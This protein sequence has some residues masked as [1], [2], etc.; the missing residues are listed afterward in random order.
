MM[1]GRQNFSSE[2]NADDLWDLGI[3]NQEASDLLKQVY[4]ESLLRRL[5]AQ[6]V[7]SIDNSEYEHASIIHDLNEPI[8]DVLKKSFSCVFDGGT[9]EHVFNFPQ[10]I[11]NCMEMVAPGGHFLGITCA[12]NFTGHGFYQF[13]PELFYRVFSPENGYV[14]EDMLLCQPHRGAPRHKA[15]DPAVAGHRVELTN[16]KPTYLIVVARRTSEVE[17]FDTTPQQSD[18][19]NAWQLG[20]YPNYPVFVDRPL[21]TR[22]LVA[23]LLP[24]SLKSLIKR[25]ALWLNK[26]VGNEIRKD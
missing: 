17:I 18:Y 9:L 24:R 19:V 23:R 26:R 1:I 11:K 12:N 14:V 4:I 6:R 16:D 7:E 25:G 13:S 2:L 10:A 3:A 15:E 22:S 8:P 5:G 20:H 21:P